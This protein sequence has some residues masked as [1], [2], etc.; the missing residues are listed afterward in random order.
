[1]QQKCQLSGL[2]G[3]FEGRYVADTFGGSSGKFSCWEGGHRVPALAY[4]PGTIQ[5]GTTKHLSRI[6]WP[7]R[8]WVLN[9]ACVC[10]HVLVQA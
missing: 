2:Q 10:P 7:C 3:P 4:W 1:M 8:V 9:F 5:P 6:P